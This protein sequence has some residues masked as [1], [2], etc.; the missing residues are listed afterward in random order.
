M[1]KLKSKGSIFKVDVSSVLTA[2]AQLTDIS[3]S[4]AEVETF[5]CT[6]L[7][8][9]SASKEYTQTGFTEPG[10]FQI[11]GFFDPDE[12]T[13]QAIRDVLITPADLDCS[14][15]L[16]DTTATV[17]TFSAASVSLNL[18]IAMSDGVKFDSTLKC[19]S[20]PTWA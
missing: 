18:S 15:D 2:V 12:G 5:D 7:D 4:G 8:A 17:L 11:S 16:T 9:S 13:H 10:E 20:L 3:Y 1:A 14:L 6:T 19:A